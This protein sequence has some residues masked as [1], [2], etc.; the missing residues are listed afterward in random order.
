MRFIVPFGRDGASDRA[1]RAFASAWSRPRGSR[2]V[3]AI[4]NLPGDG[5][6][7]GVERANAL[8]ACGVPT[9]LLGTPTTHILLAARL[10]ASASPSSAFAP[11][12]G[13]G[14]APNV[15]LAAASLGVGSVPDLVDL[16]RRMPLTYASAGLGQTIHV[17]SALFC[18]QAGIRMRH[19]AYD[20]G[21]ASAYAGLTE[22]TVQVYFDSLLG[23]RE[24]IEARIVVPL[25]VSFAVRC[26]A[27]P[28]TPT[29]R[30]CG[31]PH[32]LGVWLAVFAAN[33]AIAEPDAEA[34]ANDARFRADLSRLGLT[35]GPKCVDLSREIAACAPA[36]RAALEASRST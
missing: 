23:C 15:L 27:L 12:I 8:A 31:Y 7:R 2:S 33:D 25:A 16:A 30:E 26:D 19:R 1:A 10:G 29:L 34:L 28:D 32:A 20:G 35:G 36:W 9:L 14:A 21:S 17:C 24:R 22:G 13:L 11:A 6:L 5:G 18:E 3:V 4:E